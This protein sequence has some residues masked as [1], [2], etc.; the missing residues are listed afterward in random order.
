MSILAQYTY[1]HPGFGMG[2]GELLIWVVVVAALCAIVFR[3]ALPAMGVGLPAWAMQCFWIIVIA[4]VC[5]FC[6]K[7]LL[8]M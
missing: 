3:V 4:F 2:L 5:I 7:L 1:Y 6:I 8:V